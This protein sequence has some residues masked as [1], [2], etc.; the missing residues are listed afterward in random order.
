MIQINI[1]NLLLNAGIEEV[2]PT[3]EALEK[4]GIARRRFTQLIENLNKKEITV[5]ELEAIKVWVNGFSDIDTD[6]II[7]Q[8]DSSYTMKE[9][10]G[11]VK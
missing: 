10:L 4:M 9:K 8:A 3:D 1:K 2:R 5:A 6:R 7:E 11:L